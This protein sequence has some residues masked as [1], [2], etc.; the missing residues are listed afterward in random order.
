MF[1]W[2]SIISL[3]Y[4]LYTIFKEA[5]DKF[6]EKSLIDKGRKE[7]QTEIETQEKKLEKE[8]GELV[9][10]DKPVEETIKSLEDG[11]F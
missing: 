8:Q 5:Y 3:L 6:K 1:S 4:N 11:K 2:V 9:K 7:K 10:G